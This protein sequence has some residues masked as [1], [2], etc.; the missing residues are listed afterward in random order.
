MS[1]K[2]IKNEFI[3]YQDQLGVYFSYIKKSMS[4]QK[5]FMDMKIAI[6]YAIEGISFTA[7]HF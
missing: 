3:F 1:S 5:A 6:M 4:L 7:R 2:N